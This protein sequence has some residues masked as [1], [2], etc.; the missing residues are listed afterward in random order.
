MALRVLDGRDRPHAGRP[1]DTGLTGSDVFRAVASLYLC[2]GKLPDRLAVADK[3]DCDERTVRRAVGS[4]W[5]AILETA[6]FSVDLDSN[7]GD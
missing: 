4:S 3:L 2:K 1:K 7:G 6:P 5:D